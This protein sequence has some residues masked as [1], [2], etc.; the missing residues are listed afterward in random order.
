MLIHTFYNAIRNGK[1][2]F[3][4]TRG[5]TGFDADNNA[6]LPATDAGGLSAGRNRVRR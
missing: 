3:T 2:P 1:V 5:A 6:W 4:D